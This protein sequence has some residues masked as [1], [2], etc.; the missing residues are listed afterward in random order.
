VTTRYYPHYNHLYSVAALT[1]SAG[2]VVERFQYDAYGKQKI[3]DATGNVTRVKSA[4]GWDRGFT[5][6]IT[7]NETGL[8]HARARQYSP[9]LGRFVGR[10]PTRYPDGFNPYAGYF[11]P[12][13][14]DPTGE[15]DV[16]VVYEK[17]FQSDENGN[18]EVIRYSI[19]DDKGQPVANGSLDSWTEESTCVV[20]CKKSNAD[21]E[22]LTFSAS[23]ASRGLPAL[24]V[25]G[26]DQPVTIP[27]LDGGTLQITNTR[28]SGQT[29]MDTHQAGHQN[30]PCKE[31]KIK[32][33]EG[34]CDCTTCPMTMV[35]T[36]TQ[37]VSWKGQV[38]TFSYTYTGTY[39]PPTNG[40]WTA[41]TV[42]KK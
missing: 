24:K 6:Y 20:S 33:V 15:D 37:R 18:Y 4:V 39:N 27:G 35:K 16:S 19:L 23:T 10:D 21:A 41:S 40:K 11:V 14:V 1:D 30:H 2:A 29:D 22:I 26:A 5:G 28:P 36:L 38:T 12:G 42:E 32:A 3:T 34:G 8:L 13:K 9:T 25:G 31:A 7:D 17:P